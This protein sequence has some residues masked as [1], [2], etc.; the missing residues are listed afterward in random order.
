MITQTKQYKSAIVILGMHRSGT[1]A[2]A[3]IL[4]LLGC[5][6]PRTLI[7]PNEGNEKGYWESPLINRLNDDVLASGGMSWRDWRDFD[8]DWHEDQKHIE[9]KSR[10]LNI[11]ENEFGSSNLFVL[12][13]PRISRLAIF[14]SRVLKDFKANMLTVCLV[15]NPLEVAASLHKRNNIEPIIS[16]LIW[17]RYI[18]D[19]EFYTRGTPRLF[20]NF[21]GLLANWRRETERVSKRLKISWPILPAQVENE[22]DEFLSIEQK[23]YNMS[24]VDLFEDISIPEWLKKTFGIINKWSNVRENKSN[25]NEN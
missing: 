17:L 21:D 24:S 6:I 1:S 7:E 13:D 3:R 8:K 25:Y 9:F 2:L 10:A 12:K 15:R 14:W 20:V 19:A 18:L 4:N 11:L 5:D 22:I 23:H 16:Y